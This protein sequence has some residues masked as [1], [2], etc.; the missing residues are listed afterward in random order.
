VKSF[1]ATQKGIFARLNKMGM[2]AAYFRSETDR[3]QAQNELV[4]DYDF[5]P[6][7]PFSLPA[8]VPL[9]D[10]AATRGRSPLAE[11]P[12]EC[13][14]GDAHA[15]SIRGAGVLVG[16]L[17]TGLDADHEE[18]AHQ[19]V[20]FRYI[21]MFPNDIPPRDIRGFDTDGH[22]THVCGI[23]GG[24]NVGV[25]PEASLYVA[26]VLESETTR[27][28]LIRVA[29][30]LEWVLRQFSRPENDQKPAVLNMSLGF[31]MTP[32]AGV[33]PGEYQLRF[34]IVRRLLRT[35]VKANVLPVVAIG[36][37]RAGKYRFPGVSKEVLGVGAVDFDKK[38]ADFSGS[39]T[40]PAEGVAKPDLFGYGVGV[41]S[42]VERSYEG[43]SIYQR[44]NGT[45]MATP[46]VVGVAA[47]YRCHYPN[48]TVEDVWKELVGTAL[49]LQD[50]EFTEAGLAAFRPKPAKTTSAPGAARR[51]RPKR[52]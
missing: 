52:T 23:I 27:T 21:P 28:S 41:Y 25:A 38:V 37:D 47:L 26:S 18:F 29:S 43:K 15:R 6:N 17:D 36:N 34:E 49:N 45:S 14:V 7:F 16:V 8:R 33:P 11:W 12:A 39:G 5:V 44:F 42:S 22:G 24:K 31:P 10:V 1:P 35:L 32:P 48:W 30:G 50:P 46:Y 19:T 4:G 13:G 2:A 3:D 40:D 51:R 9:K 20:P